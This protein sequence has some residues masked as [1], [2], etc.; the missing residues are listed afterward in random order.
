[1]TNP[2]TYTHLIIGP[3]FWGAGNSLDEAPETAP[4]CFSAAF[5]ASAPLE[6][7]T[8]IFDIEVTSLGT[9]TWTYAAPRLGNYTVTAVEPV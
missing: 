6:F 3:G 2:T 7:D 4:A 1:M 8:P 9:L 5:H